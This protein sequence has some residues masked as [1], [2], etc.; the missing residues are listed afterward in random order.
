[1]KELKTK[2]KYRFLKRIAIIFITLVA[3]GAA[4]YFL[5]GDHYYNFDAKN[6]QLL[7]Q[8]DFEEKQY[9]LPDGSIINYAEIGQDGSPPIMLLHG[10]MT[11]WED[12]AKVLP[13]LSESF[14]VFAADYYGH[15]DSTKNADKYSAAAI[16][17][18]LA[19]FMEDVIGEPC[20]VSGHS[21]GGLLTVWLAANA[22]DNVVGIV[23]EDAPLFASS[24]PGRYEKTYAWLDGFKPI[25]EYLTQSKEANYTRYWLSNNH[26]QT[27]WGNGWESTVR[28]PFLQA[29]DAKPDVVPRLRVW[30]GATMNSVV[31]LTANIQD[32]TGQYDLRFGDTFY[33]GSWYAGFDET[34]ALSSIRCPTIFLHTAPGSG[35]SYY[36]GNGVLLGACDGDD[37]ARAHS[38]V[39]ESELIDNIKTGHDIHDEKPEVLIDAIEK[40]YAA[41]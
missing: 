34:E 11:S 10:Q 18:D 21:S 32:G 12:Y 2:T 23:V 6:K 28:Q 4:V 7:E 8:L 26:L 36:D 38:L 37:I 20:L 35:D 3:C 33:D 1:M 27:F 31:A 5:I 29:Y 40:V 22:S 13:K 9:T 15:G 24:T 19:L 30:P 25:H 39:S 16:G 41:R 17:K 14:H